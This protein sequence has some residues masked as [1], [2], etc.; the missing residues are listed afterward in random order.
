[1][2]KKL[3]ILLIFFAVFFIG[4]NNN[5]EGAQDKKVENPKMEVKKDIDLDI[6]ATD[7]LSYNMVKDIV[8]DRHNVEYMFNSRQNEWNFQFTKDSLDNIAKK[9]L[10]IYFG[11]SFEP[12]INDFIDNLNKNNVGVINLSRG[13]KL[14]SY[15][16]V[17]KYKENILKDNPYYLLNIDN[18]KIALMNA[19]NAVQDKDPKNRDVY[20]K[21]F[22]EALKNIENQQKDLKSIR[23]SLADYNF[24][25]MEDELSYFI[26]YNDFKVIDVS[27]EQSSV[28]V[29]KKANIEAKLKDNKNLI[30]LYNDSSLV[31]SYE[32]LIK[33]YS[34]KTAAI[35][36]YNGEDKYE[37]VL[38]YNIESLKSVSQPVTK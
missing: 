12:W 34:I 30:F 11:A 26:K 31:K 24:V 1:M 16:K 14:I 37:D 28:D 27:K 15:N 10:L 32:D 9:D 33:K 35:K 17:V 29:N 19:K 18:Y 2:K 20:E 23:D 21:N 36:I 13:V 22:A 3:S 7:K 5:L 38:K 4:C 8:K 6:M 25:V